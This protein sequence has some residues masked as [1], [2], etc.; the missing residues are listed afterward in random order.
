M[1]EADTSVSA[2]HQLMRIFLAENFRS[3]SLDTRPSLP[4][5]RRQAGL[6]AGL[7]QEN[8]A[9]PCVFHRHLWQ[10]QT[11]AACERNQQPMAADLDLFRANRS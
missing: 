11:A 7:F 3:K 10:Q 6:M 2:P 5:I 8:G 1:R 4:C 9:A